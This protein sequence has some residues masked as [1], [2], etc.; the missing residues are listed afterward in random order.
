MGGVPLAATAKDMGTPVLHGCSV[1]ELTMEKSS[2][3][4]PE[5]ITPPLMPLT[6][7]FPQEA[8]LQ[9]GGDLQQVPQLGNE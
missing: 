5:G 8:N 2:F 3:M 7:R 6:F 4:R 9:A 1:E